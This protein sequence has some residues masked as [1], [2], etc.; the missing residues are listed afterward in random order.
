MGSI[1]QGDSKSRIAWVDIAKGIG[2]IFV[3]TAHTSLDYTWLGKFINSFHMPLFFFLSGYFFSLDKYQNF[4]AFLVKKAN[5]LLLP[6]VIFA[7]VS[8]LYF[9]LRF[10]LGDSSYYQDLNIYQV[11][12]GIFYSAGTREW[13][14]FNLPLWFLTCLFVVEIIFFALKKGLTNKKH[15]VY[16][17]ILCSCIGYLD[18]VMNSFKLPWGIDVALTAI[19]FYG[20]GNL[21]KAQL[22]SLLSKP[23]WLK[24]MLV[25]ALI[26]INLVVSQNRVNLNM[27]L[28]GNYYDFYI[29]AFAG[30]AFCILIASLIHSK[31]LVYLGKN[32][33]IIMA[34]HMPMLNITSKIVDQ[35]GIMSTEYAREGIRVLL[36][37]LLL[38]PIIYLI[39]AYMPFILGRSRKRANRAYVQHN[40]IS[41]P[42]I[43]SMKQSSKI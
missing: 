1:T 15:I 12:L 3:I 6:Y 17:L 28:L 5:T 30:V 29:C 34:V 19:V 10:H 39:N 24:I 38:T 13:M 8:Y 42:T 9:L 14:D 20:L 4:R 23:A 7:A 41:E 2:I 43:H 33:L 40:Q 32:V 31:I 35:I 37:L 21:L 16:A 36:T 18:G 26:T 22:Q 27:Q 25:V 11:F